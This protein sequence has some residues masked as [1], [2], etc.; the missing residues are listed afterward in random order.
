MVLITDVSTSSVVSVS[1]TLIQCER[2]AVKS[3]ALNLERKNLPRKS[4]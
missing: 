2:S 3:M 1:A 4:R